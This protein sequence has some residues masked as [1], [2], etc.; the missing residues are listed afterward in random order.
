[1]IV[2][3]LRYSNFKRHITF[4]KGTIVYNSHFIISLLIKKN[5]YLRYQFSRTLNLDFVNSA[6]VFSFSLDLERGRE[7]ER[8][9]NSPERTRMAAGA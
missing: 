7:R 9:G 1:M 3:E 4:Q 2:W 8:Q 5:R 6:F